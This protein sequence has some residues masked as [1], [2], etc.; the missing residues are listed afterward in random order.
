MKFSKNMSAGDK[1]R[2]Y[3]TQLKDT[4]GRIYFSIKMRCICA[5]QNG[6][7]KNFKVKILEDNVVEI[8]EPV[9]ASWLN[10]CYEIN[11]E[12]EGL[13]ESMRFQKQFQHGSDTD[14]A[15]Y[16]GELLKAFGNNHNAA[17]SD[18]EL[19][20][21]VV[22]ALKLQPEITAA[23]LVRY[24]GD[25][26]IFGVLIEAQ[27][28][29]ESATAQFSEVLHATPNNFAAVPPPVFSPGRPVNPNQQ[30]M[31]NGGAAAGFYNNTQPQQAQAFNTQQAPAQQ[32]FQGTYQPQQQAQAAHQGQ[33]YQPQQQAQAAAHRAQQE[34]LAQAQARAQVQAQADAA[35]QAQAAHQANVAHQAEIARQ[36]N[37]AQQ[38]YQ[39]HQFVPQNNFT[40]QSQAG[41]GDAGAGGGKFCSFFSSRIWHSH[42]HFFL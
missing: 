19:V 21:R 24:P 18:K 39:A 9:N 29:R 10:Y 20:C 37:V 4:T 5:H 34:A 15:H 16:E 22:T 14:R 7:A 12:A 8:S 32:P 25:L 1:S 30:P 26:T 23:S 3:V 27:G 35:Q 41:S 6:S 31:A 11:W 2:T 17:M 40:F 13:V 33:A 36:A 28:K 42:S 38:A